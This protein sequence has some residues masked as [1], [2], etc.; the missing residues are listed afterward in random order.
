M[1]YNKKIIYLAGFLFS[2]PIALMS[3]INSSFLSFFVN[4]KLVGITYTL[5]SITSILALLIA[6][7]I[8]RRFGGY[9]FLLFVVG[10][11]ALSILSFA[12]A[13]HAWIAILAFIFGFALNTIIIFSLDEILKAFSKSPKVLPLTE[14]TLKEVNPTY[15]LQLK[16]SG[17][18]MDYLLLEKFKQLKHE[19]N[20][21]QIEVLNEL[22]RVTKGG[23][24][25][26]Y[27]HKN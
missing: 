8:F 16:L 27:N 3:Y 23:G 14:Q 11:N 5:G 21:K 24:S 2:I 10:L 26:M 25:L 6:P 1:Q 19:A 15:I 9:K 18:F 7:V 17:G 20:G 22:Y 4:G 13:K 12:L